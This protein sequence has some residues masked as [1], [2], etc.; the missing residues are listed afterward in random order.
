[1]MMRTAAA[2]WQRTYARY[3]MASVVALSTDVGMFLVFLGMHIPAVLASMLSYTLG[4]I[5]HW[6]MSSRLVFQDS[7]AIVSRERTKQKSLF[8]MSALIGM[9]ITSAIVAYATLRGLDPRIAKLCAVFV[10]FQT[11]YLLRRSIVFA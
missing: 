11:T 3:A 8:F 10:S 2:L 1:M 4:I 5:V 7:V 6:F 9:A